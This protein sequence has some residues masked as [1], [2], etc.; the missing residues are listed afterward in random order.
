MHIKT[1]ATTLALLLVLPLTGAAQSYTSRYYRPPFKTY[2]EAGLS[3]GA[4]T[5]T[6]HIDKENPNALKNPWNTT[7]DPTIGGFIEYHV[8]RFLGLQVALF[9]T[10]LT[11]T[12]NENYPYPV[13]YDPA[14]DKFPPLTFITGVTCYSLSAVGYFSSF[15]V[16]SNPKPKLDVFAKAGIGQ[17]TTNLIDAWEGL[18]PDDNQRRMVYL[19][20]GGL[21]YHIDDHWRAGL[22]GQWNLVNTDRLD[23]LNDYQIEQTEYWKYPYFKAKEHFMTIQVKVSYTF[24]EQTKWRY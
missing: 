10:R 22:E 18:P 13:N 11:G 21:K 8:Q 15:F 5:Y 23:G 3:V 14:R 19:F 17:L 24:G 12:W 2:W 20:S 1:I 16:T 4:S 9:S 6:G 7:M